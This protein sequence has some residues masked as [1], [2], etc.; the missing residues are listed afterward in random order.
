[1]SKITVYADINTGQAVSA[2]GKHISFPP[3]ASL[4]DVLRAIYPQIGVCNR[5]FLCGDVPPEY[6]TWLTNPEMFTRYSTH[7]RGH[8]LDHET[9]EYSVAR[10]TRRA[11]GQDLE[12]RSLYA[13]FGDAVYTPD[14][15]RAS[16]ALLNQYLQRSFGE[17]TV[18]FA[19]PAL[20]FQTLYKTMNHLHNKAF[21]PLDSDL[22]ELIRTTTGQGR[23][24]MLTLPHIDKVPG[25]YYYDGIFMYGAFTWGMP[26]ELLSRDNQNAYAGKVPARYRIRYTVPKHWQH[27]GL[28]ATP[29]ESDG[30]MY[31]GLEHAGQT[32]E[33]WVDGAELDILA[34]LYGDGDKAHYRENM[35]IGMATWKI[36]ILE[37]IIFKTE[38]ESANSKPLDALTKR[39]TDM[40]SAVEHDAESDSLRADLYG[41]VRG[42]LRNILL[43]GIGSFHRHERDITYIMRT[44]EPAPDNYTNAR[45]LDDNMIMYSVPQ[46]VEDYTAQ[47]IHPEWSSLIWARCRA[48]M[49][50]TALSLPR[51][52]LISIRT[53]ALAVSHPR[54]EWSQ[55]QKIGQLRE[56][57]AIA[58]PLK[59][60]HTFDEFDKIARRASTKQPA[61]VKV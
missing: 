28:F 47:F 2:D 14:Q 43:H 48:R 37:R 31:P 13:W 61:L 22:R 10:Y 16:M 20:T 3:G 58:R 25:L 54:A 59:A 23:I 32:F 57:W 36:N 41:F 7:K 6:E 5:L 46:G 1:M 24:E 50:K 44:D 49:T 18:A 34:D 4:P 38:K 33:T 26:T 53:D 9:R 56:K 17:R 8:Y 60:P 27:I 21:P 42:F 11:T 40:R 51:E 29:K 55:N 35:L 39:L 45:L 52:Q 15:A 12:I 30:W 19:T